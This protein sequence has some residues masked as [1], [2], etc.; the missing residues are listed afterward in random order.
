MP[1][2]FYRQVTYDE[3][4]QAYVSVDNNARMPTEGCMYV[5]FHEP[6]KRYFRYNPASNQFKLTNARDCDWMIRYVLCRDY[7]FHQLTDQTNHVKQTKPE[8]KWNYDQM[9]NQI[10]DLYDN[11][12]IQHKYLDI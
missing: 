11:D 1:C 4:L 5:I 12:A 2:R 10:Q 8:L 3:Q 6:M 9:T 7:I